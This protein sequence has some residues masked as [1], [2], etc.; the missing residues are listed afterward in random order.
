MTMQLSR[1]AAPQTDARLFINGERVDG[2]AHIEVRNPAHPDEIVGTIVRG[3]PA[4]V[5][6]AVAAA[7]A[8]QPA[9]GAL[10]FQGRADVLARAID[11]LEDGTEERAILYT[12]ENGKALAESRGEITGLAGRLR[13][14]LENAGELD[15]PRR[16]ESPDGKTLIAYRPYGVILSIVPW[17]SP[18][19]LAFSQIISGLLAGNGVVVKPP[20]SAPLTLIACIE[21]FASALPAGIIDVVT[22]LPNEIGDA[23]T[24][25]PDI[26]KIGFTGSIRA[27]QTIGANAAQTIKSVTLELG[28]ND[29]AIVLEDADLSDAAMDRMAA[30]VYWMT[31]QVC[32]AIKRIYVHE[33]IAADFLTAFKKAANKIVVGDGLAPNVTMGPMHNKQ[34]LDRGLAFVDDARKRGATIENVGTIADKDL[35]ET[36]YFMQPTVVTN[37]D[38][39]APLV[40]EEQFCPS[41]PI[42]T[43]SNVDDVLARANDSIYGLGG[44][45]WSKDVDR[46]LALAPRVASGT[47]WINAHGTRYINRRAPYGGVKQSGIGRKS[48]LEGVLDYVELQTISTYEK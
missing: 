7:K 28:G 47:V 9:W 31:G 46:A 13:L 6:H 8:A 15:T 39:N 2:P 18:V 37:I 1:P 27:A 3:T 12:R 10:T 32:M 16:M 38:A 48:G 43:F 20:E 40:V 21:L 44:S 41:V 30:S 33:K 24:T 11:R 26:G 17:N 14:F 34:Q 19:S 5:D 22:G 25:H 29:A 42:V 36:G 23:L 45:I 4:D 35:F